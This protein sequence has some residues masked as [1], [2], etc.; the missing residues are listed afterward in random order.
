MLRANQLSGFGSRRFQPSDEPGL[1][2]WLK[3][4]AI[5]GLADNDPISTWPDSSGTGRNATATA[6]ER[7]TY[8]TN[9]KNG[10]PIVR[11]DGTNDYFE[12]G[13]FS[14][15]TSGE[16]FIVIK[17]ANDP[18]AVDTKTGLMC[19]QIADAS[20]HYNYSGDQ[21]IYE[22]WGS[23]LRKTVGNP[24]P[25]L[26]AWRIYSIHSAASDYAA[27]LDGTSIFSTGTNT[28]NFQNNTEFGRSNYGTGGYYLDGDVGEIII[29]NH[30]LSA[31][32]RA[33]VIKYLYAK[34][35]L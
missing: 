19:F 16:I 22:A 27:Y 6:T 15:L 21:V 24:T 35:A 4:D 32:V 2:Q 1:V 29:Y 17:I 31:A 7:A 13:D 26:N 30:K 28:V 12:M 10:L 11:F 34:W 25:A 5:T 9:E 18:P 23:T 20:S 8:Q 33:N 14:A 3:A